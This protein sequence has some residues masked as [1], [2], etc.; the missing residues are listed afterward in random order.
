[1]IADQDAPSILDPQSLHPSSRLLERFAALPAIRRGNHGHG[2]AA[3]DAA[4]TAGER[5]GKVFDCFS[6]IGAP[7]RHGSGSRSANRT[8]TPWQWF[9]VGKQLD[10]NI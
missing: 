4:Y 6:E 8:V 10:R 9:P 5:L 7:S 1:M 3:Q 2:I